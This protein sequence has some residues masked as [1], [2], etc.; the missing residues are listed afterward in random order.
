[1]ARR[2]RSLPANP[3]GLTVELSRLLGFWRSRPRVESAVFEDLKGLCRSQGYAHAI[4]VYWMQGNMLRSQDG[5][6]TAEGVVAMSK[7]L[8]RREID[9]LAG[10]AVQ[11]ELDLAMPKP[12]VTRKHMRKTE[13]LMAEL[14]E[15]IGNPIAP[16]FRAGAADFGEALREPIIYGPESAYESQYL[17]LAADRYSADNAWLSNNRGFSIEDA[18]SVAK[19]VIA[20]RGRAME[21][22]LRRVRTISPGRDDFLGPFVF[23]VDEVA[24]KCGL[25]Q[26]IVGSVF[27]AFALRGRNEGFATAS[28]F[29]GIVAKPLIRVD[30][31][32]YLL[33]QNYTLCEAIYTTP[34]YWMVDDRDY[35]DAHGDHRGRFT[36]QLCET[37]LSAVFGDGRVVSNV[38]IVAGKRVLGEMDVLVLY[39][40]RAIVVQAKSKRLTVKAKKGNLRQARDDFGKAVQAAND[41]AYSCAEHLLKGGCALRLASGRRLAVGRELKEVYVVCAVSDSYAAL[42]FQASHFLRYERTDRIQPPLVADV[43]LIDVMAEMLATPLYFLSYLNRRVNYYEKIVTPDELGVL[44][45]HLREN[46]WIDRNTDML[47]ILDQVTP[48]LDLAMMVRR[49]GMPGKATPDGILTRMGSTVVGKVVAQIEREPNPAALELG[50]MLLKLGEDVVQM[51]DEAVERWR[52]Q[53][54]RKGGHALSMLMR[55]LDVG[56]T[57]QANR[58]PLAKG[59]NYLANMC[60]VRKYESQVSTWLGMVLDGQDFSTLRHAVVVNY[61]WERD[62]DL[63]AAVARFPAKRYGDVVGGA[64]AV[65]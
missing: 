21:G 2:Q 5:T 27:D 62:E 31:G 18:V 25:D 23:G 8:T 54:S 49:G 30:T 61:E 59:R 38:K 26:R 20:V 17:D 22:I 60:H 13:R 11:G 37:R 46:L 65:R 33:F 32:R 4:A 64:M 55:N 50:L 24:T 53:E 39:G 15:V 10:L 44:A 16:F 28:D 47:A 42:T 43:F 40:D 58:L 63:A 19:A 45:V 41:Q 48:D 56:L 14:H 36:E 57:I 52:K 1:M 7:G 51:V 35:R 6:A 9:I 3:R 29:N 12:S 34:S